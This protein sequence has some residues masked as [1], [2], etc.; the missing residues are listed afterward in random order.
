L[1]VDWSVHIYSDLFGDS[2]ICLFSDCFIYLL[3]Y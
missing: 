2:F 3:I 1:L